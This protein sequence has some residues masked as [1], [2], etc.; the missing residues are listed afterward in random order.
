MTTRQLIEDRI[1]ATTQPLVDRG[2]AKF[3]EVA[4]A[5]NLEAISDGRLTAPGCYIYR[6]NAQAVPSAYDDQVSQLVTDRFGV[7]VVVRN[8]RDSRQGDSSDDAEQYCEALREILLGW[9]PD[10][11]SAP[12]EYAGGTLVSLLNGF[13]IWQESYQTAVKW[14]SQ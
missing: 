7:V 11:Y 12:I 3:R 8:V 5:A 14:R 6:T 9:Q 4:G 10:P 1:K 2:L 13:L